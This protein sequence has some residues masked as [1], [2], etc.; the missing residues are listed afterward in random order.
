MKII[1]DFYKD[2]V[3]MLREILNSKYQLKTDVYSDDEVVDIYFSMEERRINPLPRNV[4]LSKSFVCPP[5]LQ[6]T[7]E[8]LK[9]K[10]QEGQD[11]TPHLSRKVNNA[12]DNDSMLN[13]WGIFHFHLGESLELDG[14]I[15]RSGPLV[16]GYVTNSDF[17]AVNIFNHG[18]WTNDDIIEIIHTN[19]PEIISAYKIHALS[20]STNP[21][22]TERAT[23][24]KKNCNALIQVQDRTIYGAIGGGFMSNGSSANSMMK[25]MY[26]KKF[27]LHLQEYI[28]NNQ[29]EILN[30]I[31]YNGNNNVPVSLEITETQYAALFPDHGYRIILNTNN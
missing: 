3:D 15:E 26:Q 23:L 13:E 31:E 8:Q 29:A 10:I 11:L 28:L 7:W 4:N 22:P 5:E 21:S 2:W 1:I 19:W 27:L 18:N 20:I 12:G 9:N 14:F 16:F 30:I 25:K 17:Y 6:N 24:R